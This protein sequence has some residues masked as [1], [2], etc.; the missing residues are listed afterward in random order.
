MLRNYLKISF[1]NLLRAKGY[2]FINIAGLAVGMA[3]SVL[4]FLWV[5]RELQYDRFYTKTNRLYQVYNRDVFNGEPTVWG[6]TP[7]PLAPEL[8]AL[9]PDIEHATRVAALT[10][11][12]SA[13]EKNVNAQGAFVDPDFL[14]IF[15]FSILAGN[16]ARLLTENNG[17]VIT[18]KL[19]QSFFGT[20]DVI[21]QT[22][23]IDH[24]D[25]FQVSGVLKNFPE[26]S[27]FADREYLLPWTYFQRPGWASVEWNS[28]N[29]LTFLTLKE[30]VSEAVVGQKIRKVTANRLKGKV[31]NVDH[32]EIFLFP[33]EKWHLYSKIEKGQLVG[34]RIVT[35]RLFGIIAVFILV[36]ACVN[37]VNLS[38][39]RSEKRAKEVGIR[40]V[41][42]A[43]R[44]SLIFQFISESVML[45]CIAAIVAAM[46]VSAALPAFNNLVGLRLFPDLG[47]VGFWISIVGF[48]LFT[49]LLAG[50]YPA[51]FLSSF[52]PAK[53]IKGVYHRA[54]TVFSPRKG[55]VV[56]QFSFAITLII[57]TLVIKQQIDHGQ[58][59]D[60]GYDKNNLMITVLAGEL[61]KH[62]ASFRDELLASGAVVSATRS[63]GPA[64]SLNT[65]QWGVSFPESVDTDENVEFDLFGADQNFVKTTGVKLLEGREVDMTK[66]ASDSLAVVLN[67]AAVKAM[68]LE[69]P[70]GTIISYQR[71]DWHVVGV[72]KD[73]IYESPYAPV[74][75]V[76]I[77]GPGGLFAHQWLSMRL[78]PRN[79]VA[80]NLRKAEAVF[81]K[82]NPGYPFEYSFADDTYKSRFAQEQL[83]GT[84]TGI[85]T[86]LAIFI[87]C[88]G[89]FGLAAYTAQQRTKEIGVRK[90]LGASVTRI[91]QLL[92]GDF[93][94]LVMISF[95]I[96]APVGWYAMNEWLQDFDYRISL[97]PGIFVITVLSALLIVVLTVS[98]QA[99][100]AAL[101][102]P[103][104]SLRNE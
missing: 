103:V 18:E 72:V 27:Q 60:N 89:L 35:V 48:V 25:N 92:T 37:F 43:P 28:N 21:G 32:R 81:K 101:M 2:A 91:I 96:A 93:V 51:F 44:V 76:I 61:E 7:P 90:V 23:Q 100:K 52:Q 40:K 56:L 11:L 54:N 20:T 53:V 47:S 46:V 38:T 5:Q 98:F 73:F 67:E 80:Q 97:G 42:G 49:G 29:Y 10:L 83:T 95:A 79:T 24:K 14:E 64:M 68:R 59:R 50:S 94:R 26:N 69:N 82:Y 33:A 30:G 4:I 12:L 99:V 70:V 86:G 102:N 78:N 62:Y 65:R 16:P 71:R 88:L 85:L 77:S 13:K 19:A 17:I 22:I 66:F 15:D 41:A 1:R 58:S 74:K 57:A 87:S 84:L 31:D 6:T 75:P 45:A 34:G 104:K 39:A 63:L 8:K 55:L 3:S 9:Y 36:I